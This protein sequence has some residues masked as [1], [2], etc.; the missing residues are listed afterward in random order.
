M[1]L[2]SVK[3]V[4]HCLNDEGFSIHEIP[5][6]TNQRAFVTAELAK[7]EV[8][9]PSVCGLLHGKPGEVFKAEVVFKDDDQDR[10][11]GGIMTAVRN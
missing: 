8:V 3:L 9:A 2:A 5:S 7:F 11:L 6:I 1:R 10:N 4:V